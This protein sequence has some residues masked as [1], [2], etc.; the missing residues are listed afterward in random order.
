MVRRILLGGKL[1]EKAIFIEHNARRKAKRKG[2]RK[3]KKVKIKNRQEKRLQCQEKRPQGQKN[4][5]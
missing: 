5:F 4:I 1:G 3:L 2:R